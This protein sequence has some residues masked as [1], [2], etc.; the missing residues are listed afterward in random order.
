M[1]DR[2][3]ESWMREQQKEMRE[4][5]AKQV[6]AAGPLFD[7]KTRAQIE[8][9]IA[10][11]TR[12]P[13][14]DVRQ[15]VDTIDKLAGEKGAKALDVARD[16]LSTKIKKEVFVNNLSKEL[17]GVVQTSMEAREQRIE[18]G[19]AKPAQQATQKFSAKPM[20]PQ[21]R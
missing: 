3:D 17:Q 6:A 18:G 4:E 2:I 13:A 20:T 5:R 1:G 9:K 8:F 19:G 14:G 11:A 10:D 12:L 21:N 15:I 16:A 7:D